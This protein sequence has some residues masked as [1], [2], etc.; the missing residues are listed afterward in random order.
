MRSTRMLAGTA[1]AAL[2]LTMAACGDGGSDGSSDDGGS[3]DKGGDTLAKIK[4]DGVIT[5]G[6]AGEEPYSFKKD[7]E[8]TGAT[9]AIHKKVFG[10][11][12][13]DEVKGVQ[14]EWGSLIPGLNAGRFDIVSAG[15]SILPDRCE[16]AAFGHPEIMYTTA[17]MTPKGNPEDVNDMHDVADADL[18]LAVMSGAIES[19]YSDDLGINKM[20]VGSPQDGM[21][22]VLQ[23][24]A[25]AF[26][27][28][29]ISLRTMAENNP[30]ADVDVTDPFTAIVDGKKQVGAGATVFRKGDDELREA[31]NKEIDKIVGDEQTFLDVVGEFGFTD[32]ERPKGEIT[33]EQLCKGELPDATQS[34]AVSD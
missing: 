7:G 33:T 21:D 1:A 2:A 28:T 24:R 30:D 10:E 12:G 18:K 19:G 15:M 32:A 26:A 6:I 23:E 3:S 25:D 20:E 5:V 27:L 13:V 4:D 11:M 9:I 14:T 22:A 8:L 29:G 31:Y 17:L 34:E 16:Q